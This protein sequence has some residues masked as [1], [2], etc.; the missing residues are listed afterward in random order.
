MNAA[1][2]MM[3]GKLVDLLAAAPALRA[4]V[5]RSILVRAAVCHQ[6]AEGAAHRLNVPNRTR[7]PVDPQL[8]ASRQSW[9]ELSFGIPSPT[10]PMRFPP[11]AAAGTAGL[12]ACAGP[13]PLPAPIP[14]LEGK[15]KTAFALQVVEI[16]T[17]TGAMAEP[18]KCYYVH[19]TGWLYG[20]KG[21][22]PVIPP[23]ATLVFDVELMAVDDAGPPTPGS[24]PP[25]P[26]C[27]PSSRHRS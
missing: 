18:A 27:A 9:A 4:P 22:P 21:R 20:E 1:V 25:V 24:S 26:Q 16:A 7:L 2:K 23:K 8:G 13:K 14:V 10:D 17:G 12:L 5:H 15:P 19:Y 11:L 3:G 6:V